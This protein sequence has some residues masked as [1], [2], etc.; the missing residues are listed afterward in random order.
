M[1]WDDE[2]VV[3]QV[4]G[5][6][7]KEMQNGDVYSALSTISCHPQNTLR[8]GHYSIIPLWQKTERFKQSTQELIASKR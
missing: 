6:K 4:A 2:R 5:K 1:L 7:H 8:G 3:T